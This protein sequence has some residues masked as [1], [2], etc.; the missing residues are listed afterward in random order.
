KLFEEF[1][2]LRK[3][4]WGRHFWARGYFCSTV[5]KMTEEM[6]REYLEHHF[7]P[8]IDDRFRLEQ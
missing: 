2:R 4:Y 7:E 6:I 8:R 1:P 3:R 5:G